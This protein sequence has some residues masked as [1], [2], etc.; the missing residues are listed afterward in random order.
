MSATP[1][2]VFLSWTFSKAVAL[3]L[4]ALA[5]AQ[6]RQFWRFP[7][8]T[9]SARSA[10]VDLQIH[11]GDLACVAELE[12][13]IWKTLARPRKE[14]GRR[15]HCHWTASSSAPGSLPPVAPALGFL[16]CIDGPRPDDVGGAHGLRR[17]PRKSERSSLSRAPRLQTLGRRPFRC[18]VVNA[19]GP[20]ISDPSAERDWSDGRRT[21]IKTIGGQIGGRIDG[22]S[23]LEENARAETDLDF[24]WAPWDSNPQ[25]LIK[26]KLVLGRPLNLRKPGAQTSLQ[27][28]SAGS[29]LQLREI[30]H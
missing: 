4:V 15:C 29:A 24:E 10:P 6:L 9:G 14:R 17:L 7:K 11:L 20:A 12:A 21:F 13:I 19:R 30:R 18:K 23:A 5:D 16:R 26:R 27:N 2:S 22:R 8:P 1:R 28:K 25:P 3:V